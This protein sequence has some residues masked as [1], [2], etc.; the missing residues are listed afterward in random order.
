MEK[1]ELSYPTAL[2]ISLAVS[3]PLATIPFCLGLMFP[4]NPLFIVVT[5][6]LSSIGA[7]LGYAAKSR[8]WIWVGAISGAILPVGSVLAFI[9]ITLGTH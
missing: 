2:V 1:K 5:F 6:V 9:L 8:K 4:L 3:L 7:S